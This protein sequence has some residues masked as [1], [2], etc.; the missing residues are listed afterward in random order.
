MSILK[1]I[2]FNSD[3]E[4]AVNSIKNKISTDFHDSNLNV[5][6]ILNDSG[7]AE[8]YIRAHFKKITSKTPV[9]F[10]NEIRIKHAETLIHIYQNSLALSE[11]A[12]RCGFEDYIYFSRKFKAVNGLSPQN[13]QKK[14]LQN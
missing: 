11:I 14:L 10:L 1:N 8:D 5:T 4:R 13:Y 9:E 7:Y 6:N 12:Q 3:I 2:K